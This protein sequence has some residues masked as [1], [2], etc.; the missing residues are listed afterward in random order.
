MAVKAACKT[1]ALLSIA[2]LSGCA[3][4]PSIPPAFMHPEGLY[5]QD[6]PYSRLYVEIDRVEGANL[7]EF[8]VD[9]IKAFLGEHCAKSGGI[10]VILDPPVP[11]SDVEGMSL[12]A[13]SILCTNGPVESDGPPPAYLHLFAYDGKTTF[14]GARPEP[15]VVF[16]CPSAIFWNVDYARSWPDQTRID[17]L[18]HELGHILG[19]CRNTAHGDGAHCD[20]QGCLM[21]PTPDM[22]SQIGGL[23]H[24]YFREHRLCKDCMRDLE[25]AAEAP[26]DENLSFAGPFLM[27]REDGYSVASMAFCEIVLAHP[28][29][30]PFDWRETLKRAKAGLIEATER[31]QHRDGDLKEY[32]EG[33]LRA[34]FGAPQTGT[35]TEELEQ[36][37]AVLSQATNDPS[38]GVRRFASDMLKKRQEALTAQGR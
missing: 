26:C 13:A 23:V 22:L 33:T 31:T 15:R 1:L 17:M 18:R 2:V 35:L 7:P 24:L 5:L 38:A 6:E 12:S 16:N 29:P 27:R 32:H 36:D 30:A 9:E 8:F 25:L 20:K 4:R 14:K 21:F 28:I 37:I 34:F 10:S 11:A 19:L 3:S